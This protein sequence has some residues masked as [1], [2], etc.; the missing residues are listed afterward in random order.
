MSFQQ[1]LS[2]LNASS[3]N[4]EV[5]GN[6]VAN[7]NTI[8]AKASRAEFAD[9]YA[10]ALNGAG[11][12]TIGIG[13]N[14]AAVTQQFTQ[15]NITTTEN[16]LDLAI[17][18]NGFFEVTNG[19]QTLYTRNGQFQAN[20][21]GYI[22]NSAGLQLMGYPA[23][24]QG[25]IQPGAARALQLPTGGVDPNVTT[26][27]NIEMNLDARLATTLPASGAQID[28]NDAATY[29]NATSLSVYDAKG[30]DVAVT[31][32]FQK[33]GTDTWNVY[34]TANGVTL[35][36][37]AAAPLPVTSVTFPSDGSAPTSPTGPVSITIPATTNSAGAAT[38][39]ITG[40][41]LDLTKATQFG[42][43]FGVTDMSQD[44]YSA[45]KLASLSIESSGI[46]MAT[47]SNGQ[48]KPA[49]QIELATFRNPQGL[50]PQGGNVWARTFASGDPTVGTPG[51][52]NMGA[53]QASALEESNVDLTGELVDM[54]T[55]QRVYQANA[56]TIKTQDA[57]LQTLVNLR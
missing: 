8:G 26:E 29:N 21:D 14:L 17:N 2:G 50:S 16:P 1:G 54:I 52:G 48:S 11:T 35:A 44:G 13:V 47:Y 39:P 22:V 46:V 53:L 45:G 20:K 33:S 31:Y 32:Y 41:Q 18:G 10:S 51:T 23:D 19:I 15:G 12:T 42:S 6:N 37:T 3:K 24:D 25:V 49:G 5:I 56:Q 40:V 9:M 28:F 30:Q 38:L 57:V 4:L 36:G 43:P 7:A 27:V 55:A 34:A